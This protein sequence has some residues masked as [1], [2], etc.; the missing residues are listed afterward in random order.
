VAR[1]MMNMWANF[2][3][4][5]D[6]GVPGLIEW[7]VWERNSDKYLYVHDALQ[8]KTGYSGLAGQF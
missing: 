4:T 3:G 8:V 6:P 7:P 5:G 2:A 1:I